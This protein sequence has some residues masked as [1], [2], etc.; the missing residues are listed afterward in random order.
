[1]AAPRRPVGDGDRFP[2]VERIGRIPCRLVHLHGRLDRVVPLERGR[3]LFRA[4][5]ERSAD[6]FVN[7]FVELP[8]RGHNDIS[9]EEIGQ[10]F[11]S[12]RR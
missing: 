1:M 3:T 10:A 2:S 6:G 8:H 4:A 12:L 9:L 5:P 11:E 7:Q